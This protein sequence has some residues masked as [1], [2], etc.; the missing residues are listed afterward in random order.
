[1]SRERMELIRTTPR[2]DAG[3]G[4]AWPSFSFGIVAL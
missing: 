2:A 4:G 3:D 1:M